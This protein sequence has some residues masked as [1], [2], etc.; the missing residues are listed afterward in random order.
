M[1]DE[2]INAAADKIRTDLGDLADD[3]R[4]Y[5]GEF[6]EADVKSMV[7][8][9]STVLVSV[10]NLGD[11]NVLTESCDLEMAAYVLCS[12]RDELK[13]LSATL[14]LVRRLVWEVLPKAR[15]HDSS[16]PVKPDTIDAQNLFTGESNKR[17]LALWAVT[18]KIKA[19]HIRSTT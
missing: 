9:D 16:V 8:R 18:F 10:L 7:V 14:G 5:F 4:V 17:A 6:S 13:R 19:N 12:H 2:I 15:F 3:V 11:V 1:L